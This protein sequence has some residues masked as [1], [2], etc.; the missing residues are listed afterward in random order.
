MNGASI[1]EH[2][3][4]KYGSVI[5]VCSTH[6]NSNNVRMQCYFSSLDHFYSTSNTV[7]NTVFYFRF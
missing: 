2:K 6:N 1:A 3:V 7:S 5:Q 4:M